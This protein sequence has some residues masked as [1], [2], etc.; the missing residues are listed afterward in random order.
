M[1][2]KTFDALL[3][4]P[5]SRHRLSHLLASE[6]AHAESGQSQP[7]G[8]P[9]FASPAERQVLVRSSLQSA[10]ERVLG[11]SP[12]K[13]DPQSTADLGLDSL[14]ALELRNILKRNLAVDIPVMHLLRAQ[15]LSSITDQVLAKLEVR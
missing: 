14:T 11:T 6:A 1:D 15:S 10:L 5:L 9:Q 7:D 8:S 13:L 4:T 2:W 12:G 3:S